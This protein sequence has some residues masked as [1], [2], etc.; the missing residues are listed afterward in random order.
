[1][2]QTRLKTW[3]TNDT[4]T[5]SDLNAEFNNVISSGD[6]SIG[7]PRTATW[8]LDGQKLVLDTDADTSIHAS[9][10]DQIDF[11][12]GGVDVFRLTADGLVISNASMLLMGQVFS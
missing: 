1:M 10:D 8:D 3:A 5:A 9:T 2:A 12:C 4:L 6:Q 11:E 7:T